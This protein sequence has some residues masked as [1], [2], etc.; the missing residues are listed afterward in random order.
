MNKPKDI[1]ATTVDNRVYKA[2]RREY[3]AL[4]FGKCPICKPHRGENRVHPSRSWKDT[5]KNKTQFGFERGT[6]VDK[7]TLVFES[8]A[9]FRF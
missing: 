9:G 2:A 4:K 1:M 3:V 8:S 5:T 6:I 7:E